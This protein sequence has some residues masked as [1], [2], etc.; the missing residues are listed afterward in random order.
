MGGLLS[1]PCSAGGGF[2]EHHLPEGDL[3]VGVKNLKNARALE[4][5][6]APW[7]RG[8]SA[9]L[10]TALFLGSPPQKDAGQV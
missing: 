3:A 1:V 2:S 10:G 9:A 4:S 7:S 8:V 6:S 5:R